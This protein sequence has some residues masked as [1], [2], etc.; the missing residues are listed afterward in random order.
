M[1][2]SDRREFKQLRLVGESQPAATLT[3]SGARGDGRG[4]EEVRRLDLRI[5]V[6][7]NATG[8]AY[9]EL[10]DTKILCTVSGPQQAD[11]QDFLSNGKLECTVKFTA[12]ARRD[13]GVGHAASSTAFVGGAVG[14]GGPE[15]SSL[16]AS[17][18]AALSGSVRLDHYPK[19]LL[20]V[21]AV[22][23]Q[24][25][26]GVLPALVSCASLALGHAGIQLYG[27]VACCSAAMGA[28][29]HAVLDA[30][31]REEA[32]A[33]SVIV[34]AVIPELSQLPLLQHNGRAPFDAMT[35]ALRLALNGCAL[36]HE[37]MRLTL[38][39]QDEDVSAPRKRRR[40]TSSSGHEKDA[41]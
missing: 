8:S 21:H 7:P 25:G 26:G 18:C 27:L 6:L 30:S 40:S 9:L 11:G 24:D 36:I 3:A 31:A 35:G 39:A 10:G 15:A 41:P 22:V 20:F 14:T 2:V 12:F 23:L 38:T 1:S 19:S 32:D 17:L 29:G 33:A 37:R 34:A 28:D 13:A 16:Q 4:S 5:G